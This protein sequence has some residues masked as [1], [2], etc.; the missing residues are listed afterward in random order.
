MSRACWAF[1][2]EILMPPP[3]DILL[4]GSTSPDHSSDEQADLSNIRD[5]FHNLT[6]T[7][8]S[9]SLTQIFLGGCVIAFFAFMYLRMRGRTGKQPEGGMR[10]M[11]GSRYSVGGIQVLERR[12]WW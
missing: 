9:L 1:G 4:P 6:T 8:T 10:E 11:P 7:N 12:R 3:E 2:F 5:S